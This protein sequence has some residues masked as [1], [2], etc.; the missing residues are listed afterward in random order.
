MNDKKSYP[1]L[2]AFTVILLVLAFGKLILGMLF[3]WWWLG[4]PAIIVYG[5]ALIYTAAR[6][7]A[8]DGTREVLNEIDE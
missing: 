3:S 4:I 5:Y 6:K 7:G 8:E 2:Q 1:I